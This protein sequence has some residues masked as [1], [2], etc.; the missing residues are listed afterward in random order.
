[1]KTSVRVNRVSIQPFSFQVHIHRRTSR[2]HCLFVCRGPGKG[3]KASFAMSHEALVDA[4]CDWI[5]I[6]PCGLDLKQTA[7][8]LPAMT[9][10][11]WW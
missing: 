6:C 9:S 1:M 3:A 7:K 8:E 4:D 10:Q 5:I 2:R 11:T